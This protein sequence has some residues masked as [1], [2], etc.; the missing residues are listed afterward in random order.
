MISRS[1]IWIDS[2]IQ[3]VLVGR[4]VIYWLATCLYFGVTIGVSQYCDHP[5]WLFSE[6]WTAWMKKASPWIPSICLLLPLVLYDITRASHAFTGPIAR[7]G[8]QLTKM[9]ENPNCTPMVLRRDDYL[10]EVIEPVN[11]LQQQILSLHLALQSQRDLIT[12]LQAG[13][14]AEPAV[15]PEAD[16]AAAEEA[17]LA[18]MIAQIADEPTT[19][20]QSTMESVSA[21]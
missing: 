12:E 8:R 1:R 2:R 17:N 14:P 7:I 5:D 6:H 11:S 4:I 21:S 10:Q 3:G 9:V 20:D 18:S 16:E 15:D 13:K 19:A